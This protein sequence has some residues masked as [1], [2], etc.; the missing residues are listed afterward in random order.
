MVLKVFHIFEQ[1][2]PWSLISEYSLDLEEI[3]DYLNGLAQYCDE[4]YV[5]YQE[6]RSV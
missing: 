2:G 5:Q 4:Q 6:H 1:K 3:N